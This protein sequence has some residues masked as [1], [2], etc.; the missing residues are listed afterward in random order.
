MKLV[1][2]LAL[3]LVALATLAS[4]AT[5]SREVRLLSGGDLTISASGLTTLNMSGVNIICSLN[6]TLSINSSILKR[7]GAVAGA[8]TGGSRHSCN[9]GSTGMIDNPPI[10]VYYTSFGGVLPSGIASLNGVTGPVRYTQT[11]GVWYGTNRCTYSVSSLVLRFTGSGNVMNSFR[12][13]GSASTVGPSCI[14]SVSI[15]SGNF[16]F[17]GALRSLSVALL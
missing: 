9:D 11:G 4:G 5:A 16:T 10:V 13:S 6:L 7:P 12:V 15:T 2:M 3:A 17:T 1:I 8:I 14:P